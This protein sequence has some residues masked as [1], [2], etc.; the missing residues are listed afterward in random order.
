MKKVWVLIFLLCISLSSAQETES[1]NVPGNDVIFITLKYNRRLLDNLF[2]EVYLD[3]NEPVQVITDNS[4]RFGIQKGEY[5]EIEIRADDIATPGKDY[6]GKFSLDMVEDVEFELFQVGSIR[7][8]VED[9]LNNVMPNADLNFNC[10]NEVGAE[11]VLKTDKFGAFS[12]EFAPIGGCQIYA[13]KNSQVGKEV[14][15]V[16]AGKVVSADIV[17]DKGVS[18]KSLLPSVLSLLFIL[19]CIGAAG[20]YG[21]R[22]INKKSRKSNIMH[23]LSHKEK[24]VVKYLLEKK[25]AD[26]QNQISREVGIPKTSLRRVIEKLEKKKIVEIERIG[27]YKKIKISGWFL[28]QSDQK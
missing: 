21:F 4:G 25:K 20:F 11:P 16:E 15:K 10:N 23:T 9:N 7:G 19:I 1:I 24:N 22:F 17:L 5:T 18:D 27:K 26:S 2:V 8:Q 6:Y 14:V 28:G 3:D 12:Y 13:A